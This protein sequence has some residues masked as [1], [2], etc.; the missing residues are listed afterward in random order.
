MLG[1]LCKSEEVKEFL[2]ST[3]STLPKGAQTWLYWLEA[4]TAESQDLE[5]PSE[6]NRMMLELAVH[7]QGMQIDRTG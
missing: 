6:W 3:E 2:D 4:N 5:K 7:E 1:P